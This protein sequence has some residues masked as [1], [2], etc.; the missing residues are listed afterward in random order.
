[1]WKCIWYLPCR[2]HSSFNLVNI[3]MFMKYRWFFLW[4]Y[5]WPILVFLHSFV[6]NFLWGIIYQE[7]NITCPWMCLF[8]FWC[9]FFHASRNIFI[10]RWGAV[11]EGKKPEKSAVGKGGYGANLQ[12]V[13]MCFFPSWEYRKCLAYKIPAHLK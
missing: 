8:P 11:K 7:L 5:C 2:I 9:L 6:W 12:N 13:A 10:K 1:M 4:G 3:L